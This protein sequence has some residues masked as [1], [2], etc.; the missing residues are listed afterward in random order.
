MATTTTF[1]STTSVSFSR[2]RPTQLVAWRVFFWLLLACGVALRLFHFFDNRSLW[3]DEVY[4]ANSLIRMN[5]E[6]LAQPA[7]EYEQKAPILFL[8]LC[9]L[10]VLLF[11]KQEMAL[12]LVPLL[13]SLGALALFVPVSRRVLPPLG[14][15]VAMGI[16]ALAPPLIYHSVEIKQY[17]AELLATVAAVYLYLRYRDAVEWRP[18]LLWTVGGAALVWFSYASIFVLMAIAGA[19]SLWHLWQRDWQR[20][21]R[22]LVPFAAWLFSFALNYLLFTGKYTE[23]GW[24]VYWFETLDAFMPLAASRAAVRWPFYQL[25]MALDYPLGLLLDLRTVGSKLPRLVLRLVPLGCLAIGAVVLFRRQR[26]LFLVL[27]FAIL[28]TVVASALRK[29]PVYE[30]LIV[31]L[32]PVFILFIASGCAAVAHRLHVGWKWI[33]PALLLLPPLAASARQLA[34]P[35]LFGGYKKSYFREAFQFVNERYQPGD[36]VYLNWNHIPPYRYYKLAYPLKY[37][38]VLGRDYRP[39][40]HNIPTYINKTAAEFAAVTQGHRGWLLYDELYKGTIGDYDGRPAWYYLESDT[41]L[42]QRLNQRIMTTTQRPRQASY[43]KR[44]THAKLFGLPRRRSTPHVQ[45]N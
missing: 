26:Q 33:V 34:D 9:R 19:L 16:L 28:L 22:Q 14:A 2:P 42:F 27:L 24:L 21:W 25:Y 44:T 41:V 3:I 32:A 35:G 1:S 31:F 12:R 40:S 20:F 15:A 39:S 43:Q 30:R 29:Y 18:L 8:W 7:L 13:C 17:S 4:V 45:Q 37:N 6:Q 23:S 36:V 11:G 10:S 38:A 5:F